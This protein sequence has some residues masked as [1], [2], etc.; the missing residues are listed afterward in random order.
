M[1]ESLITSKTRLKLLLK[2]FLN[3][4][5]IGYLNELANEFHESTNAVRL[6]LNRLAKANLIKSEN[7]GRTKVYQANTKHPL[8]KEIHNLVK[9]NFGIDLIEKIINQLGDVKAAYI[10]GD[11]AKG[12]DSGII[13][14]VIVGNRINQ[15]YLNDLITATETAINRKIR[16]L[17]LNNKEYENLKENLKLDKSLVVWDNKNNINKKKS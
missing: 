8:F 12:K 10:T 11:Y 6:E 7:E 5:T 14:L 13:D 15:S 17:I 4:G 2:F 3:P 16:I 1:L 9:K